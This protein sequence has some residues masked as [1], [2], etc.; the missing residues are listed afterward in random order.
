MQLQPAV[1]KFEPIKNLL[2]ELR[3]NRHHLV[4]SFEDE[5]TLPPDTSSIRGNSQA[6]FNSK[7]LIE[8][9][10]D[11]RKNI[12]D[13][14]QK[15]LTGVIYNLHDSTFST[16][17]VIGLLD[18]FESLVLDATT[19]DGSKNKQAVK[20]RVNLLNKEI[21]KLTHKRK[22][23]LKEVQAVYQT[24]TPKI[25]E[26]VLDKKI[27]RLNLSRLSEDPIWWNTLSSNLYSISC[28]IKE[29]LTKLNLENENIRFPLFEAL[30]NAFVHGNDLDFTLPITFYLELDE[31]KKATKIIVF[32]CAKEKEE[33]LL[34]EIK[35]EKAVLGC[36][37]GWREGIQ[38]LQD[39]GWK[40]TLNPIINPESKEKT[41]T[42]C[43]LVR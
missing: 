8:Q 41:G 24:N 34:Q 6:V 3:A 14:Y 32:D 19:Q 29:A 35:K 40:V 18:I 17:D 38:N 37:Y 1:N 13:I 7:K 15:S 26:A 4:L 20:D 43:V 27:I 16:V 12:S 28:D 25:I 9:I 42:C 11:L 39:M 23:E 10:K 33:S 21:F 30:K 22:K 5:L 36:L 31:K 2:L